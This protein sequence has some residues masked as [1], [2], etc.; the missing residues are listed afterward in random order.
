MGTTLQGHSID[1]HRAAAL[2]HAKVEA[3]ATY[4]EMR[5]EA[6]RPVQ[7]HAAILRIMQNQTA[8]S[9][10]PHSYSSAEALAETDAEYAAF[11][12]EQ[13]A[14]KRHVILTRAKAWAARSIVAEGIALIGRAEL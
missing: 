2:A 7:K 1:E 14:H 8:P 3:E 11:L 12:E 6:E 13:R 10:K 4:E 9:G 5:L